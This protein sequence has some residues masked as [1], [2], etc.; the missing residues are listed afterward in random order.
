M[1]IVHLIGRHAPVLK[2]WFNDRSS[3]PYQVTYCSY[4][5]QNEFISLLASDIRE[6]IVQEVKN[7]EFFSVSADTTPD[8]THQDR[9]SNAIR[10]VNFNGEPCERLLE[11]KELLDKTG[12]GHV[13]SLLAS[14]NKNGLDCSRIAFQTY[15]YAATMSG[16]HNGAQAKLSEKLERQIPYIPCQG[17]RANTVMEH[18]CTASTLITR[19]FEIL[20]T[21][22]DFFTSS[23]K[24]HAILVKNMQDIENP[25]QLRN[26]SKT[27]WTARAES[28]RAV[29]VSFDAIVESL[30]E[31]KSDSDS[32]SKVLA[33]GLLKKILNFDFIAAL[34]L[35]KNIMWKTKMMTEKLQE[36]T[37]NIIDA[38]TIL[39]GTINSLRSIL[40]S[41]DVKNQIRSV[42]EF[43]LKYD[44][45]C[46]SEFSKF[47]RPRRPPSRLRD[48][49][50]E[51][52]VSLEFY[53]Y[54]KKEF[55]CV[56]ETLVSEYSD[57]YKVC[58]ERAKRLMILA[59]PL[60]LG[61]DE[62]IALLCKLCPGDLLSD[63]DSLK[64]EMEV[65]IS[66]VYADCRAD[67]TSISDVAKIVHDNR[68]VFPLL[69][70]AYRLALTAPVTVAKNERTCSKLKIVKNYLRSSSTDARLDALLLLYCEHD[71]ADAIDLDNC[72][73]KWASVRERRIRIG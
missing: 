17:H 18:S 62:D 54:Y 15:D 24:R 9:I 39:Q 25:L 7:A 71:L 47:H 23:T 4:K 5:S 49:L 3:R 33:L 27:R 16:V 11:V 53:S 10:Y 50:S 55:D 44:I 65:F 21:C 41:D 57:N 45:D 73:R 61:A 1:Q 52:S 12:E 31:I 72:V 26:L 59:P 58:F 34:S 28:V 40:E 64:S 51:T 13:D 14:I 2:S 69:N 22:F 37:L 30:H 60:S 48:G 35:M 63:S 32:K 29:W 67:L 36:E 56:L 8:V 70:R 46:Y 42:I 6:K 20:Q 68:H 38:L 66:G 43:S 19:M